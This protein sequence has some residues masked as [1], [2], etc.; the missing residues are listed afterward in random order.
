M[1]EE[2]VN[3]SSGTTNNTANVQEE[4]HGKLESKLEETE[5]T[6]HFT[7]VRWFPTLQALTRKNVLLLWAAKWQ[8]FL[9]FFMPLAA[10]GLTYT[11]QRVTENLAE[12]F[13]DQDNESYN[14]ASKIQVLSSPSNQAIQECQWYD[15][16]GVQPT[17]EC[18]TILYAPATQE[19]KKTLDQIME[20]MAKEANLPFVPI[21]NDDSWLAYENWGGGAVVGVPTVED[22]GR[23]LVAHPGRAQSILYFASR[24]PTVQDNSSTT[25]ESTASN[26]TINNR[27]IVHFRFNSTN[28]YWSAAIDNEALIPTA[29]QR[30]MIALYDNKQEI[31]IRISKR[32]LFIDPT[33]TSNAQTLSQQEEDELEEERKQEE[34]NKREAAMSTVAY[35]FGPIFVFGIAISAAM[36]STHAAAEKSEGLIGSLRVAGMADSAYWVSW[37]FVGTFVVVIPSCLLSLVLVYIFDIALLTEVSFLAI[38]LTMIVQYSVV[39]VFNLLAVAVAT[40]R[41]FLYALYFLVLCL[42][43]TSVA[44]ASSF[45]AGPEDEAG[46]S[47]LYTAPGYPLGALLDSMYRYNTRGGFTEEALANFSQYQFDTYFSS[48]GECN[49]TVLETNGTCEEIELFD[50]HVC[51]RYSDCRGRDPAEI[52]EWMNCAP[53]TCYFYPISDFGKLLIMMA[54]V[55]VFMGLSWYALQVIPSGNGLTYPP[56]F[57][58]QP[59]YW[60]GRKEGSEGISEE[61][62]NS[63]NAS[64]V[65]LSGLTK[66][67]GG[68]TAVNGVDMEL[69][70]GQIFVLLGHNGAG[71]TTLLNMLTGK[72][73]P[74]SGEAYIMG[75]SVNDNIHGIQR[76]VG[77]VPQHDLLWSSLSAAEHIRMFAQIKG[78]A[79]LKLGEE[80]DH[81]LQKVHLVDAAE[82]P[83]GGYSGGMKRR[84]SIALA[85][86][87]GPRIVMLDEPTTGIDPLNRRR[88]WKLV[89]ELKRDRIVILTTHLMQE[90]DCLG[91]YIA[92]LDNGKIQAQGTPL[93]LKTQYGSGYS[94]SIVIDVGNVDRV[95][96]VAQNLMPNVDLVNEAAG[97]LA[98]GVKDEDLVAIPTMT[99]QLQD[100]GM[101]REWNISQSTIEEVFL[102][103]ASK[104]TSMQGRREEM[105]LQNTSNQATGSSIATENGLIVPEVEE[106]GNVLGKADDVFAKSNSHWRLQLHA[107]LRKFFIL[108]RRHWIASLIQLAIPIALM[109]LAKKFLF[110]DIRYDPQYQTLVWPQATA[111][112]GW[113]SSETG[114]GDGSCSFEWKL[115]AAMRRDVAAD[116]LQTLFDA[117]TAASAIRSP[118]SRSLQVEA[119]S[120]RLSGLSGT[121]EEDMEEALFEAM[122]YYATRT[123]SEEDQSMA[124]SLCD[125]DLYCGACSVDPSVFTVEEFGAEEAVLYTQAAG[126]YGGSERC[127]N[128]FRP[129]SLD[130]YQSM[131]QDSMVAEV[132]AQV[133]NVSALRIDRIQLH[134]QST[135]QSSLFFSTPSY[136]ISSEQGRCRTCPGAVPHVWLSGP[137]AGLF[138]K[139]LVDIGLDITSETIS[140]DIIGKV[141]RRRRAM[142]DNSTEFSSEERLDACRRLGYFVPDYTLGNE[143]GYIFNDDAAWPW[144][145]PNSSVVEPGNDAY[146]DEPHYG[147]YPINDEEEICNAASSPLTRYRELFPDGGITLISF[148]VSD[149]SITLDVVW[150]LDTDNYRPY[151][152]ASSFI[153]SQ[154][155]VYGVYCAESSVDADGSC[156]DNAGLICAR[157]VPLSGCEGY[158]NDPSDL[159]IVDA[160]Y[161]VLWGA[162]GSTSISPIVERLNQVIAVSYEAAVDLDE[163]SLFVFMLTVVVALQAPNTVSII[164]FEKN[165]RFVYAMLLNGLK[166]HLYWL[167]QY[168]GHL[169]TTGALALT[170]ILLGVLLRLKPF[171]TQ[172]P[173]IFLLLA[174]VFF[175]IHCQF[176]SVVLFSSFFKK[177][178]FAAVLV[179]FA[180]LTVLG[181]AILTD[182]ASGDKLKRGWPPALSLIPMFGFYRCLLLVFWKRYYSELWTNVGVMMGSHTFYLLLGIYWQ[183]ST[184]VGALFRLDCGLFSHLFGSHG[185]SAPSLHDDDDM[186]E[187]AEADIAREEHRALKLNA[188]ETA[189]KIVH[190]GKTF[191]ARPNP[192]HAVVDVTMAM[193]YGEIFGLLGPNGAGKTTVISM[194]VGQLTPSR[195]RCFVAGHDTVEE[196]R[197]ALSKLGIVPQFDVYYPE[198]TVREHLMLYAAMKGVKQSRQNSWA[199]SIAASVGLGAEELFNR[200]AQ[201][202]SGGMRRRL[203][204]A[205]ALLSQ[206]HCLFL[207]EPTTGLGKAVLCM[208]TF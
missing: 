38:L 206:P 56:W 1:K 112:I 172:K 118:N 88:I 152:T 202:L 125:G 164:V 6:T 45:R 70:T 50:A 109:A 104:S 82:Q 204:I 195:G 132:T 145:T 12:S 99:R 136:E 40:N 203:S 108:K 71:K 126:F 10:V 83:A 26:R 65:I 14:A 121:Q 22:M 175:G 182:L 96:N 161:R 111:Y 63:R 92:I 106:D 37:W 91:D 62:Q 192:K 7:T 123:N 35:L 146:D 16:Y 41:P 67:F 180:I 137:N 2:T 188:E 144:P 122:R 58:F 169:L 147:P 100:E 183:S 194:L 66:V 101:I 33:L 17:N 13:I 75:L 60:M 44:L 129:C 55:V 173:D 200:Q 176:G 155:S 86:I 3:I 193:D 140:E 166:L 5:S 141:V 8:L 181:A 87:G 105:S 84:L 9:I 64:S 107:M 178:R 47:F 114:Q 53:E 24:I 51:W 11:L 174:V 115:W 23:F 135:V 29:L 130:E 43:V 48:F 177:E 171:T 205:V 156:T 110:E 139:A 163:L 69:K 162:S 77:S 168:L 57:I 95:K 199:Q 157:A 189:I 97:S 61:Q 150:E 18:A 36:L 34:A 21:A 154:Q 184:G 160:T 117:D 73:S 153:P 208:K 127:S 94:L 207:D 46:K 85:G 59:K 133:L 89:R 15:V 31:K 28:S 52:R 148:D 54:Q 167:A 49:A 113:S 131:L 42:C 201:A 186:D 185:S 138:E 90:A 30:A 197:L 93:N 74:T 103:L 165:Q 102:R 134:A 170:A 143:A 124:D 158:S 159:S 198:L 116:P 187:L 119:L 20:Y 98:F 76:L 32:N 196:R 78:V 120:F 72:I 39:F 19:D 149:V 27:P 4:D 128:N 191:P 151:G 80:I 25:N 142:I 179:G 68:N 190:L 81:V 79:R